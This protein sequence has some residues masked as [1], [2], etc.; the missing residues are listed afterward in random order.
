MAAQNFGCL[1]RLVTSAHGCVT[2]SAIGKEYP[3]DVK[4]TDLLA[5]HFHG[6]TSAWDKIAEKYRRVVRVNGVNIDVDA[7][8]RDA[9]QRSKK[10]NLAYCMSLG[11]ELSA[12]IAAAYL[13]CTYIEA[14][15]CVKFDFRG[16][17]L[18]RQT[19][20]AIA[21]AFCGVSLGVIGGFYGGIVGDCSAD[22]ARTDRRAVFSRGGSDVTG[23]ICAA[24]LRSTLYENR[25]DVSGVCTA[26]PKRVFGA[27][28]IHGISY[29][30]MYR[31]AKSG[32]EVLHPDAVRFCMR[33]G[34]PICVCGFLNECAPSTLISN[35]PSGAE[36]LAVSE[37]IASN[38]SV[39]TTVLHNLSFDE[40]SLRL[41]RLFGAARGVLDCKIFSDRVEVQT[42]A[43]ILQRAYSAFFDA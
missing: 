42:K 4:T 13:N 39:T 17:L 40:V 34:I 33:A 24:A 3:A 8:L 9:L 30:E 16:R 5:A 21:S 6:D 23:A 11:E 32:A 31:L 37:K 12:K 15:D 41:S 20:A 43:S 29:R 22:F 38:G 7:L 26:N 14:A 18:W 28:V 1:A 27:S 25:T 19:K 2:V 36:V 35:C 10:H